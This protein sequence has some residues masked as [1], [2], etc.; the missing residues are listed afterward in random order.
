MFETEMK[1]SIHGP[2]D[3]GNTC[4]TMILTIRCKSAN[5]SKSTNNI[6]I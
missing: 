2:Y 4:N 6:V 1:L 5:L 3:E